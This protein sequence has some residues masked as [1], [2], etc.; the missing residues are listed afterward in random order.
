[1]SGVVSLRDLLMANPQAR[2]ADLMDSR[3]VTV[4]IEEEIEEIAQLFAK[5]GFKAIPVMDEDN[6]IKGVINFK[7]LLEVVAPQLGK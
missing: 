1:L 3:V 7:G 4:T 5:Y 6:R 2:L